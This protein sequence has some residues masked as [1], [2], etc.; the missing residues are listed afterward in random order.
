MQNNTSNKIQSFRFV[1]QGFMHELNNGRVPETV[2]NLRM[3]PAWNLFSR[4]GL[5]QQKRATPTRAVLLD[6]NY[7]CGSLFGWLVADGWC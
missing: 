2:L 7:A 1:R 3:F 6:E 5:L 4:T